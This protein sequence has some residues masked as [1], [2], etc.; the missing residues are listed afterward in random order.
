MTKLKIAALSLI[1]F[2]IAGVGIIIMRGNSDDTYF[3][4]YAPPPTDQVVHTAIATDATTW[5]HRFYDE[6][7]ISR[8]SFTIRRIL[9]QDASGYHIAEVCW[10]YMQRTTGIV[11]MLQLPQGPE[12]IIFVDNALAEGRPFFSE[13]PGWER[14]YFIAPCPDGYLHVL[15]HAHGEQGHGPFCRAILYVYNNRGELVEYYLWDSALARS[16]R[17]ADVLNGYLVIFGGHLI[18]KTMYGEIVFDSELITGAGRLTAGTV[19]DGY[20]YAVF[21]TGNTVL[22]KIDVPSGQVVWEHPL[23][24]SYNNEVMVWIS[25]MSF[26]QTTQQ[27]YMYQ[28]NTLFVFDEYLGQLQRVKDLTHSDSN[29]WMGRG[30]FINDIQVSRMSLSI[31]SNGFLHLGM[32]KICWDTGFLYSREWVYTRLIDDAATQRMEEIAQ[33]E[34]NM[35]VIRMFC[36]TPGS[37]NLLELFAFD[38]NA[39]TEL[40]FLPEGAPGFIHSYVEILNTAIFAGTAPWDIVNIAHVHGSVRP[41]VDRGLLVDFLDYVGDRF[42]DNDIYFSNVFRQIEIDGGL[43]F[44]PNRVYVPVVLVP[45]DFPDIDRLREISQSWTWTD[46]L[47]IAEEIAES[48]GTPPISSMGAVFGGTMPT[49][50]PSFYLYNEDVLRQL[51]INGNRDD[52]RYILEI[53]Y[54]LAGPGLSQTTRDLSVF[55]FGDFSSLVGF[56]P[57]DVGNTH[58][59]LPIPTMFGERPFSL[60][61]SGSAVLATGESTDLATR[62]LIETFGNSADFNSPF[63]VMRPEDVQIERHTTHR[64]FDEYAAILE[65]VNS[66]SQLPHSITEPIRE[67]VDSLL[68]GALSFDATIDRI[69]DIM[70]LYMNE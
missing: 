37:F 3:N 66:F 51:G 33:A 12:N 30:A 52:I 53:F 14:Y 49:N 36:F 4:A 59:V 62:F 8:D 31:V 55:T 7:A 21:S 32:S 46:F 70:W 13:P 6:S 41:Y 45:L 69:A 22:R 16:V 26:C 56:S 39:R 34:A 63:T 5:Q 40:T 27:L 2:M 24:W 44:L 60:L 25:D 20:I 19:G 35:P 1:I 43:Y 50:V 67:A 47:L 42:T 61:T 29:I 9:A 54:A 23:G 64:A 18:V 17:S 10:G 57:I 15:A 48:T 38:N 28:F 11:Q 65:N 68:H 58:A